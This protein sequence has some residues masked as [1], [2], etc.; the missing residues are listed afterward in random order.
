MVHAGEGTQVGHALI[1]TVFIITFTVTVAN[2]SCSY[3]Y[4]P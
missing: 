1:I 3:S 2:G 4:R